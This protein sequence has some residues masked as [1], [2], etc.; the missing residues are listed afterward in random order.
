M[1]TATLLMTMA[2]AVAHAT[3][4]ERDKALG[5]WQTAKKDGTIELTVDADGRLQGK[6]VDGSG[7]SERLDANNPDPALRSRPLRGQFILKGLSY[8]G[9]GKWSGGT[10]YDPNNGKTYRL[11]VETSGE[12][13][14]RLRGYIGTPLLGRT[15]IWTRAPVASASAN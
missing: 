8:D 12:N 10:I 14:L 11:K 6:I 13:L 7:G 2:V 3:D 9:D 5:R 1:Q 15:E 4:G